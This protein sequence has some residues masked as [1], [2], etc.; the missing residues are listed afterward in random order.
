MGNSSSSLPIS[1]AE[2]LILI[3]TD[4]R[5]GKISTNSGVLNYGL[6]GALIVELIE[7]GRL[8]AVGDQLHISGDTITGDAIQDKAVSTIADSKP[9]N[10]KHWVKRLANNRLRDQIL[11]GL[12][13]RGLLRQEEHR[14]LWIFPADRYPAVDSSAERGIR[15]DVRSA[16]LGNGNANVR[17]HTAALI[18]LLHGCG[19][20]GT[21][22]T[23]QER[24]QYKRRIEEIAMSEAMG[25]TVA[26]VV[27][28]AQAAAVA[29]S[30]A[31]TLAAS[32]AGTG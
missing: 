25:E 4:D 21:V 1:L 17:P 24:K 3:A 13:Q 10:A 32:S 12:V 29:A 6:S 7:R 15:E 27:K 20:D 9:R 23:R 5:S 11:D 22:F 26:R 2:A 8:T 16:V 28:D 18:G 30:T 19:L 31:A 14:I